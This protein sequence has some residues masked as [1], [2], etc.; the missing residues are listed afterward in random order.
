MKLIVD[1]KTKEKIL[2]ALEEIMPKLREGFTSGYDGD[3]S[4]DFVEGD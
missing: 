2:L 1:G 3:I 4:W